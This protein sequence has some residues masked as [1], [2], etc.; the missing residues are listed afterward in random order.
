ME[1]PPFSNQK[2]EERPFQA[3]DGPEDNT[4][5]DADRE[6]WLKFA[7][8][9]SPQDFSQG[10]L[11]LQCRMLEGVRCAMVLLGDPDRGPYRP[12]AVWPDSELDM[13]HLTPAAERALKERRGLLTDGEYYPAP[14]SPALTSYHIAYPIE[15][16]N[17]LHG[18]VVLEVDRKPE[19]EIQ[20]LMRRL[21]WGAAWFEVLI[22]RTEAAKS[23][24]INERLQTVIDMLVSAVEYQ[25]FHASAMSF[26]TR[27]AT[28]LDC[29]RVSL[30]FKKGKHV[31]LEVLSHSALF[32]KKM[33][34]MRAIESAM[35]EA[36]DQQ[37]VLV[38]PPPKDS[39]PLV[40]RS[41]QDLVKLYDSGS[42]LT[43]PLSYEGQWFGCLT[44]ERRAEKPFDPARVETL[45]TTAALAGP[46]LKTKKQEDRWIIRKVTDSFSTQLKRLFGPH[47][48]ARKLIFLMLAAIVTFFYF[49]EVDY[50]VSAPTS[51]EGTI[52]RVVVAPFSG[53]IR[54]APVRPGDVVRK[55]DLLC[56]LDDRDLRLERLKKITEKKQLQMEYQSALAKRD[57]AQMRIA[58]ARIDQAET[59]ISLINSQLDR[60]KI[61]A[62]FDGLVMMGDL[63][64]SLGAPVEIGQVL[65]QV[66][67]L[68][69]Y[70]VITEVDERDINVI[71]PKQRGEM[72]L[73]SMPR[74]VFTFLVEKITP[75]S[76]AKEGRTYFRVEGRMTEASPRLRPGMEGISKITIDRRKLI[77]V[78]THEAFDWLRLQL[79]RW[80]A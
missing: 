63:S 43:I 7:E 78:W 53:F 8:A 38:Y 5:V 27:L 26:V 74:E 24:E 20:S 72:V 3:V 44:L 21:H 13:N 50:R 55:G 45:E 77:W 28:A 73:A 15:I 12:V 17:Q 36:L 19:N 79:W 49:Y 11:A 56:L 10:W 6:L 60:T 33:N 9:I 59:Q 80:K 37:S 70:R 65:F 57:G 2:E 34:L 18:V 75:V 71:A 32:G 25:G 40:T 58:Q 31:R 67:P 76:T 4:S 68:D 23:E 30:G 69:S 61:V 66:A 22:R 29:D 1:G 54:E 46:I 42:I 64:Q 14:D 16:S 35:D 47:Y 48:L 62:P 52:M 51:L 39:A 41:H